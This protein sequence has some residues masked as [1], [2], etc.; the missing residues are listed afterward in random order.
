MKNTARKPP[1][2]TQ[3]LHDIIGRK[4]PP[5]PWT[6]AEN[7]PWNEPEFSRRMLMEHLSQ[8]HDLA[9]RR[10]SVI[11]THIEFILKQLEATRTARIIDLACGPGLYLHRLARLGHHGVGI[12]FSP[13]S[14]EYAR[15][16]AK[17]EGLDCNFLHADLREATFDGE[18]EACLLLFGQINVFRREQA[19]DILAK[20][21]SCLAPDG[22]LI[23]EPQQPSVI[24]GGGDTIT[25]WVAV[26]RGLFADHPHLL[27][28]ERFWDESSRTATDRW[29]TVD[30]ESSTV[31]RYAMSTC[32]YS[33]DELM[34]HL[35]S[36]G[37]R[38]V[39]VHP[40]LGGEIDE[41]ALSLFALVATK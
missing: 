21:Y 18:F 13:A 10:E 23:L 26:P 1:D 41:G 2:S 9:S 16:V 31:Q 8:Q 6:E 4:T 36:V 22:I 19:L 11:D 20:A 37:F 27:L 24:R 40:S 29:Y 32:S 14:I 5:Q 34:G 28:Y 12:D 7:I 38:D 33:P 30:A 15:D 3:T 35:R 39:V 25:D 17:R